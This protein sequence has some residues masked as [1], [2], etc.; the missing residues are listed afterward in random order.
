MS[1]FLSGGVGLPR[2]MALDVI[3]EKKLTENFR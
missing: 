2:S 1:T 3:S